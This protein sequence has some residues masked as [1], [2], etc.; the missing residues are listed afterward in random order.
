[1]VDQIMKGER[2][3]GMD[4]QEFR[5]LRAEV[6]KMTKRR[7]KGEMFHKSYWIEPVEGTKTF[8]KKTKTY[9]KPKENV[10]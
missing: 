10:S 4:Y 5:F 7:L 8:I 2:P 3:E 9:I 6:N 1:M